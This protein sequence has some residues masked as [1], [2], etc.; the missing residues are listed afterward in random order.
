MKIRFA[1]TVILVV[2]SSSCAVH[3]ARTEP[4]PDR[5]LI[6]RDQLLSNHFRTA[7]DAVMSLRGNWL[8]AHN[9]DLLRRGVQVYF[10][11]VR[12]GGIETL[13]SIDLS[14][15]SFI[16]YHDALTASTRWGPGHSSGVIYVA[17]HPVVTPFGAN[18]IR[19]W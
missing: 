15:V 12:L 1:L 8:Q 5:D 3:T 16:R 4:A 17:T 14:T 6:T 18:K 13:Y 11:E 19:Q 2:A 9:P 7:Y 10:N